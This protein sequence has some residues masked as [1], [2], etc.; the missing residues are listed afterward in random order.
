M[1]ATTASSWLAPDDESATS[2][3][4]GYICLLLSCTA[5]GTMFVPLKRVDARDGFFVQWIECGVVFIVGS[6]IYCIRDFP[7]F[8]PIACIGGLLYAT[9]NVFSV[10]I[11][12][13]IG[14]GIGFLI[15]SSLQIAVGWSVARFGLFGWLAPTNVKSDVMNYIGIALTLIGGGLLVLVKQEPVILDPVSYDLQPSTTE[16]EKTQE[17]SSESSRRDTTKDLIIR[18]IP[19]VIMAMGLACMHGFMMSPIDILKQ[20]HPT[21]DKFKVFDYIFP[22]YS[23]VFL[24]STIYF[25]LYSIIRRQKAY[26]EQRLVIPSIG[27]GILWTAGMTLWFVSSDRLSQVVAYPITTRLPPLISAA[28]DVF[29]YKTV[30]GTRNLL[31]L[32]TAATIALTGVILIALSNQI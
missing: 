6:I 24:F 12:Q 20:K 8:E 21:N 31:T 4:V 28:L 22:F 14:M 13:G 2:T 7:T 18:K 27:Y 26:I 15:W 23:S 32:L 16:S 29:V 25:F 30:K 9:G 19:F 3:V 1:S 11:V 17:I 5:F 10:P